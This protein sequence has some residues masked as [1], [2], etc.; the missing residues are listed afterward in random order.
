MYA[1]RP[2]TLLGLSDPYEAYCLDE[3]GAWLLSQ[4]KDPVYPDE[5]KRSALSNKD[6]L[7]LLKKHGGAVVAPEIYK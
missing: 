4:K 5:A 6:I 2:S 7:L 1:Q 3:A